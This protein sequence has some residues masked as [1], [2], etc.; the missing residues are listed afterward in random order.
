MSE[1]IMI[2]KVKDVLQEFIESK[3]DMHEG[4]SVWVQL[5]TKIT[6]ILNAWKGVASVTGGDYEQVDEY[7]KAMGALEAING[8]LNVIDG[9]V[10]VPLLAKKPHVYE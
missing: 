10:K 3:P 8:L 2:P 6:D 7:W 9:K 1:H 5:L 4:R